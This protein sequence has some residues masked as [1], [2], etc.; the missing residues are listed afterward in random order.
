MDVKL[1]VLEG[2]NAGKQIPVTGRRFCIGRADDCQLRPQ[3]KLVSRRHC[4]IVIEKDQITLEDL[5]SANG[6]FV[7][8]ERVRQSC[9]LHHGDRLKIGPLEF[10]VRCEVGMGG[11]KK[12]KVQ[13]VQEA[14]ARTL[15]NTTPPNPDELDI[16]KWLDDEAVADEVQAP[17]TRNLAADATWAPGA[18]SA[19]SP[20]ATPR[21][22]TPGKGA[23]ATEPDAGDKTAS[24]KPPAQTDS[25][26]AA[27]DI[28]RKY[29]NKK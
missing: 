16:S 7:N 27:A 22:G 1:I 10:E 9:E 17:D 24:V 15:E 3:S 25:R 4:E 8:G 28:L 6:T 29:L 5:G 11:R 12:P 2:K 20:V 18:K 21:A 14:V 23:H 13:S 19:G 26:S